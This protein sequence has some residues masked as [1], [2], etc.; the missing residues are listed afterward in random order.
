MPKNDGNLDDI[1]DEEGDDALPE[2]KSFTLLALDQYVEPSAWCRNGHIVSWENKET[3]VQVA[4]LRM[5]DTETMTTT[6]LC[7]VC[8]LPAQEIQDAKSEAGN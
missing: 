4:Y 3:G 1:E 8:G 5:V 6:P 2:L 7:M